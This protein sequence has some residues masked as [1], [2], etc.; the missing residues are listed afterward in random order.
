M[1]KGGNE[2]MTNILM[3]GSEECFTNKY[4]DPKTCYYYYYLCAYFEMFFQL[5]EPDNNFQGGGSVRII[6]YRNKD[7]NEIVVE[8]RA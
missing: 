3:S 2:I 1:N 8:N 5:V 4:A 6:Q 7:T